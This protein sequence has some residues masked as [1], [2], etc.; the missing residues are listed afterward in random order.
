VSGVRADL[1][2]A[3]KSG[4]SELLL[5]GSIFLP[6]DLISGAHYSPCGISL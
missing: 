4:L 1:T 3:D 2:F 5:L 6:N